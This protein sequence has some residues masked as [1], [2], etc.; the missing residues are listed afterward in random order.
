ME[1][2]SS[3]SKAANGVPPAFGRILWALIEEE[4]DIQLGHESEV[5]LGWVSIHPHDTKTDSYSNPP[6]RPV[7]SDQTIISPIAILGSA[8]SQVGPAGVF[9]KS[10]LRHCVTLASL[11][12]DAGCSLRPRFPYQLY[13]ESRAGPETEPVNEIRVPLNDVPISEVLND[14]MH[15][16][17][18]LKSPANRG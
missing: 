9:W 4:I 16:A 15:P 17:G 3:L 10:R 2:A 13:F 1:L 6:R 18:K 12:I 8:L 11:R 14:R 7:E 5:F